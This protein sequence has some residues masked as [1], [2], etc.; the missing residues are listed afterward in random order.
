MAQPRQ[1]QTLTKPM[2]CTSTG[3]AQACL[4]SIIKE[5][6]ACRSLFITAEILTADSFGGMGNH[7]LQLCSTLE[8]IRLQQLASITWS[9]RWPWLHSVHHQI[10]RQKLGVNIKEK[11]E[12]RGRDMQGVH[13]IIYIIYVH[14]IVNNLINKKKITTSDL[15]FSKLKGLKMTLSC[16]GPEM[17]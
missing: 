14:E 16:H 12:V 13:V 4:E 8:Q 6:G 5:G 2:V 1:P 3:F 10:N 9:L 11:T 17:D 15:K 7:C